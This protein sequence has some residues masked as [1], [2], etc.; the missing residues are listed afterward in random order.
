V[1]FGILFVGKTTKVWIE[2]QK[3]RSDSKNLKAI[4]KSHLLNKI[5]IQGCKLRPKLVLQFVRL[6]IVDVISTCEVKVQT[7][8]QIFPWDA[9]KLQII[10]TQDFKAMLTIKNGQYMELMPLLNDARVELGYN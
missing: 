7:C 4:T 2:L 1:T 9:S 10:L 6:K 3:L 8:I 5:D